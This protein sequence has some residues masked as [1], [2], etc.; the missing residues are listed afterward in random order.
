MHDNTSVTPQALQGT[1]YDPDTLTPGRPREF[2]IADR[3]ISAERTAEGITV[4]SE[5]HYAVVIRPTEDG[6]YIVT[7]ASETTHRSQP[8]SY[9]EAVQTALDR[10]RELTDAANRG[11]TT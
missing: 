7:G 1:L 2:T 9:G 3:A 10:L 8:G 5:N 4:I 11:A 6:Q